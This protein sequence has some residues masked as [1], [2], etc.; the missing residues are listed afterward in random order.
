MDSL[1]HLNWKQGL[2]LKPQHFQ[3]FSHTTH[4]L[5]FA[6]A[7]ALS[8]NGS[9]LYE[10][11]YDEAA[12]ASGILQFTHLIA[13]FPDGTLVKYPGNCD[14]SPVSLNQTEA[15][16]DG[17]I[18]VY[19][20][21]S[22]LSAEKSNLANSAG[23]TERYALAQTIERADL[24]DPEDVAGIESLH[25]NV[26]VFANSDPNDKAMMSMALCRITSSGGQY[27]M[28]S[29]FIPP[30]V[31]ISGAN[32]LREQVKTMKQ[33]LLSRYEQLES[34]NGLH[35]ADGAG[36]NLR[37]T[38]ALQVI[39][40]AI[41]EF[42]HFDEVPNVP[43]ETVYLACR[44]LV[45]KLSNFS[46]LCSIT[47]ESATPNLSLLPFNQQN[48]EECFHRAFQLCHSL[49]NQ[50][51]VSPELLVELQPQE[52]QCFAATLSTEML[53]S[54]NTL[55]LR[56]RSEQDLESYADSIVDFAKLGADSQVAIYLKRALPGIKL[57]YLHR[58]PLGIANKPNSFYFALEMDGFEWAQMLEQQR[59]GFI[60]TEQ[61]ADLSVEV[62]AVRG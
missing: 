42:C 44:R 29:R 20:G 58:K 43:V 46:K 4:E 11:A 21:L 49:L 56:L 27:E 12:L 37:T 34:F 19:L 39:T 55:Y 57:R 17:T 18:T 6:H 28:D 2:F 22:A 50:L 15:D 23:D 51:T 47:G 30:A 41:P 26:G 59:V 52:N 3:Q 9:G 25:Y 36:S 10:C 40:D 31:F 48:L 7:S 13:V 62:I 1:Q 5:A 45:A 54:T 38:M 14:I 60:W 53:N 33:S 16:N 32:S 61:P 8:G 24:F 35:T